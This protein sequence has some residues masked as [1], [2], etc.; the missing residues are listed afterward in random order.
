MPAAALPT[1]T[2]LRRALE[3]IDSTIV[4]DTLAHQPR[5]LP[6]LVQGAALAGRG[7]RLQRQALLTALAGGLRT[8]AG[9]EWRT[10]TGESALAVVRQAMTEAERLLLAGAR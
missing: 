8:I 1:L 9:D 10:L 5:P 6:E 3:A 2:D 4:T 7:D